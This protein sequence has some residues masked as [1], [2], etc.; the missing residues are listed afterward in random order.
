MAHVEDI[1]YGRFLSLETKTLKSIITRASFVTL[2]V[3]PPSGRELDDPG[4][5]DIG[6]FYSPPEKRQGTDQLP[7]TGP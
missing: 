7:G 5:V 6:S 2:T 3:F 1:I 4:S